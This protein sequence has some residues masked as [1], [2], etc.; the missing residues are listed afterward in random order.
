MKKL[1]LLCLLFIPLKLFS[2]DAIKP[3]HPTYFIAGDKVDQV[4]YQVSF[5]YG[6][7]YP[8]ESGLYLSYTQI[9]KWDLYEHSS[10]FRESN[11][12]PSIFW[13]K[14]K[15]WK[16]DFLRAIPYEHKSNGLGGKDS[17]STDRFFGEVQISHG[18]VFN[19]GIREK[20]GGFYAVSRHNSDIKR[21]TGHFETELFAQIKDKHG[22]FGHEKL[23]MKGEWTRKYYWYEIGFTFR[24][25]TSKLSPHIYVQYYQGYN[26]FLIDYNKKTQ[27]IRAGFIFR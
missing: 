7:W 1:L 11:Y 5:K 4:K 13:E 8:Y 15:V 10:P 17:R 25:F 22:Y 16:F 19:F 18:E 27:A 24:I 23:Y 26:E 14:E 3:Y 12:N 2:L 20:I 9:S 21:Y 6:L